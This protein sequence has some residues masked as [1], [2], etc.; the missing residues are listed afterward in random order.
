[1]SAARKEREHPFP[2]KLAFLFHPARYKVAYG[3]RGGAK[4]WG[5]ADALLIQAAAKPLR[6]LCAREI[7]KSIDE[8]VHQLLRDRIEALGLSGFYEV[9]KTQ[10]IGKNGSLFLFAGLRHNVNNIK[11]K[12]GVDIVWVEE[13]QTVSRN[14]WQTLIPTIRKESSE[15]WVSFNPELDTDETYVRFVKNPPPGAVVQKVNWSDNPWFPDV[16]RVEKDHLKET[17]PDAYLTIWEGH[18]RQTLDGAIFA[19]E[20]RQATEENR[21]CK[22]PYAPAKPVEV[23][24]DLGWADST[25]LWFVQRVGM[26]IRLLKA[27]QDRQRPWSDY[28]QLIQASNFVIS[29][30]WLPHDAQAKQLGTGKSIEDMT[31]AAMP[32]E[33]RVRVVPKLSVADGINAAREMFPACWFDEEGTADGVQALRRYRYEVDDE[34]GQFSRQPL[35]NEDSHFADAFRYVAVGLREG[36]KPTNLK[37]PTPPQGRIAPRGSGWMRR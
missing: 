4:S 19:R 28:L 6:I 27:F 5:F 12:E 37:L 33:G 18:C 31:R 15:I 24:V 10:I 14:S 20:I 11:S 36:A 32:G 17:D 9:Q 26:E 35:H 13:A 16:L 23:F 30:I 7:Q 25:S 29:C 21:I 2:E 34:T 1:M 22:V 3:G 8:S